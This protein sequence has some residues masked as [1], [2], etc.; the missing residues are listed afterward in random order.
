MATIRG[1]DA[2]IY[3]VGRVQLTTTEYCVQDVTVILGAGLAAVAVPVIAGPPA[4]GVA[5]I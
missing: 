1:V 3:P 4:V 5:T 2:V